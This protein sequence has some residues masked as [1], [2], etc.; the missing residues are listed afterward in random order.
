[1][2]QIKGYKFDESQRI[3][4]GSASAFKAVKSSG[5]E[6]FLKCYS[7]ISRPSDKM[8]NPKQRQQRND[9]FDDFAKRRRNMRDALSCYT[10]VPDG[11]IVVPLEYFE[12]DGKFYSATMWK[13]ISSLSVKEVSGL[14]VKD[15]LMILK[16]AAS[17]L[18]N[19]HS[20]HVLHLD[21]KPDNMPVYIR[22][23]SGTVAVALI[24]F[25]ESV[26]INKDTLPDPMYMRV[27]E[28]YVPFEHYAYKLDK[29]DGKIPPIS[30]K[31]DIFS[32]GL[33]F[34]EYWTGIKTQYILD[35]D[36]VRKMPWW[37][38]LK[39]LEIFFPK[40]MPE[41]LKSLIAHMLD[42][43]PDKRP[44]AEEVFNIL[45]NEIELP[46]NPPY[47]NKKKKSTII[48]F[49]PNG[50]IGDSINTKDIVL[51]GDSVRLP[52]TNLRKYGYEFIGWGLSA[53]DSKVFKAG[54]LLSRD[55]IPE[56]SEITFYAKWNKIKK[57]TKLSNE[58]A[59]G[60]KCPS[61]IVSFEIIDREVFF[62]FRSG[63]KSHYKLEQSL[64]LGWLVKK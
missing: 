41:Y 54:S 13:D 31:T 50:G 12:Y 61:S 6:Y 20:M 8:T 34:Y 32:L 27:T 18:K 57:E 4:T 2:T 11:N 51:H 44:S 16:T 7:D 21:I 5:D 33:I 43:D 60:R 22:K 37:A 40:K 14:P 39:Q 35:G 9:A 38:S 17:N 52:I 10:T 1:M 62:T 59:L 63:G 3:I 53:T 49:D 48:H 55:K 19:L 58:Y 45:K 42:R 25:D 26:A 46:A 30:Y 28:N 56:Q 15:K 36:K 47:Y 64:K 29:G 23:A 24:D